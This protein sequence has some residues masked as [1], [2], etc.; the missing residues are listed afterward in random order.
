[1]GVGD[2]GVA[3][4]GGERLAGSRLPAPRLALEEEGLRQAEA[5]EHR[6]REPFVDKIVDVGEAPGERLDV[7]HEPADLAGGLARDLERTQLIAAALDGP[8]WPPRRGPAWTA[9]RC[10]RRRA[11]RAARRCPR[12]GSPGARRPSATPRAP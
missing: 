7:G 10:G 12:W 5:Q 1:A 3:K 9:C 11:S 4:T 2:G 6:R 8:A